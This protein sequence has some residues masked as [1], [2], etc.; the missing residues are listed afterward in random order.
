MSV[1]TFFFEGHNKYV[2]VWFDFNKEC[3]EIPTDWPLWV[4]SVL[5]CLAKSDQLRRIGNSI[6]CGRRGG[7]NHPPIYNA[8]LVCRRIASLT[9]VT[10]HRQNEIGL[11]QLNFLCRQNKVWCKEKRYWFYIITNSCKWMAGK[12]HCRRTKPISGPYNIKNNSRMVKLTP[13]NHTEKNL[14]ITNRRQGHVK[15]ADTGS[16]ARRLPLENPGIVSDR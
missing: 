16:D 1:H 10:S 2:F 4:C 11:C 5:P 7:Y 9:I 15:M 12:K 3:M 14:G 13:R 6:L 8:K